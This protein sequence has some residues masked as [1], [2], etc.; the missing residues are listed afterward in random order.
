[1][2]DLPDRRQAIENGTETIMNSL[3]GQLPPEYRGI[4]QRESEEASER[5]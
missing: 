3:A 2:E 4:Y 1:L 5:A